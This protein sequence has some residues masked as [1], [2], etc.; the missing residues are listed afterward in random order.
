MIT[1]AITIFHTEQVDIIHR[2]LLTTT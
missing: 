1:N 2:D